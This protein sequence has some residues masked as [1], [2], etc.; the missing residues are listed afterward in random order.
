MIACKPIHRESVSNIKLTTTDFIVEQVNKVKALDI[1]I[2]SGL[3]N[4][5][6]TNNII[7]KVNYRLSILRGV[8]KFCD[9]R[10][11][12]ILMNSLVIS[13]FRYC[14]PILLNSNLSILSKLQTQLL[15]CTRYILG[16]ESYKMSTI[17]IMNELKFM[18]IYHM[19]TKESICFMHKIIY[20]NSP[21]SIYNL[22]TYGNDEKNIRKIRKI[23][24][25]SNAICQ[26]VK[27]SIIHRS[28]FLYN[29]LDYE[30]RQYNPK[31]LKR[32]LNGNIKYYFPYNKIPKDDNS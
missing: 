10:T 14:C 20:N 4:H 9:R 21:S 22:L 28:V 32:Y 30:V 31:K 2:T 18:T 3:T 5:A 12:T 16:F 7:S 15:K 13:I 29:L 19:I 24:V 26:K 8:F 17:S 6:M 1:F 11:K 23:R 27:D 25:K